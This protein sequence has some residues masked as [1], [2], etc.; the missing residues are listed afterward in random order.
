MATGTSQAV[1]SGDTNAAV[2][3]VVDTWTPPDT[4]VELRERV[5]MMQR[6]SLAQQA[7]APAPP[8]ARTA[9]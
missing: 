4:P 8:D 9:E 1:K 5:A 2:A 7:A 3:A 6:R